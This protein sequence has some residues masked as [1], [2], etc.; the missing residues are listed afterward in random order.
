MTMSER[1]RDLQHALSVAS[2]A[3]QM[4]VCNLYGILTPTEQRQLQHP[5]KERLRLINC[6]LQA[7]DKY[8]SRLQTL[9][10]RRQGD[11]LG[12]RLRE[13]HVLS[14]QL[15]Q[16]AH[17]HA[18]RFDTLQSLRKLRNQW[19]HNGTDIE[20]ILISILST[21]THRQG[22]RLI[23]ADPSHLTTLGLGLRSIG[24]RYLV[25]ESSVE[26]QPILSEIAND[27]CQVFE[28]NAAQNMARME[29]H[30]V[31]QIDRS[32][33]DIQTFA[34]MI[35]ETCP[36]PSTVD[37]RRQPAAATAAASTT[38]TMRR[39]AAPEPTFEPASWDWPYLVK[40]KYPA[41]H[42]WALLKRR[43]SRSREEPDNR[44]Y[45]S[46]LARLSKHLR[47]CGYTY[48][49]NVLSN[50]QL[51]YT[52]QSHVLVQATELLVKCH[53]AL[54]IEY[55]HSNLE[56]ILIHMDRLQEDEGTS[57]SDILDT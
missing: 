22:F 14:E 38:E 30:V 33:D 26:P 53:H 27:F 24:R 46:S 6:I 57:S 18:R 20:R 48:Y 42:V 49:A 3:E 45:V 21:T 4:D 32:L 17:S 34:R 29:E 15:D 43:L 28:Q 47:G 10:I 56:G 8:L 11:V 54:Q 25:F 13:L 19:K 1:L 9:R 40:A 36:S 52:H 39:M 44:L 12:L 2:S 5:P 35:F 7:R 23:K 16:V 50:T 37:S 55:G 51:M 31:G 41:R